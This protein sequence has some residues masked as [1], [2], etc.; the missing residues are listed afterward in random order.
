MHALAHSTQ[1]R[2]VREERKYVA[3]ADDA[4]RLLP[5]LLHM[6][7][8]HADHVQTVRLASLR[9]DMR[10]RVSPHNRTRP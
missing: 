1:R 10:V 9:R 5:C 4:G 2:R 3:M 6:Y 7:M 8:L